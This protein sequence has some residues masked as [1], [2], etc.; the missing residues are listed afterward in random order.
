MKLYAGA[1]WNYCYLTVSRHKKNCW[2]S[3]WPQTHRNISKQKYL[4]KLSRV[5][6]MLRSG[7]A[8][9]KSFSLKMTWK[10]AFSWM[11]LLPLI[12]I[13]LHCGS[14]LS[15][16][17]LRDRLGNSVSWNRIPPNIYSPHKAMVLRVDTS[18]RCFFVLFTIGTNRD[19]QRTKEK[20]LFGI[21]F[22]ERWYE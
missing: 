15:E 12:C 6:S 1:R 10:W 14:H 20:L 3:V 2:D 21:I 19:V 17:C 13:K 7:I 4:R 18:C 11:T 5:D 8:Y 22:Q 16:V 9:A